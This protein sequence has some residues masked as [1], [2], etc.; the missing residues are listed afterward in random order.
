M[1]LINS[2]CI[3]TQAVSMMK[4]TVPPSCLRA[5]PKAVQSGGGMQLLA[6]VTV[7]AFD[8]THRELLHLAQLRS[9]LK[10]FGSSQLPLSNMIIDTQLLFSFRRTLYLPF[11]LKRMLSIRQCSSGEVAHSARVRTSNDALMFFLGTDFKQKYTTFCPPHT[12][13]E[14]ST[15]TFSHFSTC[16]LL[17]MLPVSSTPRS[18]VW[19]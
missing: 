11:S 6:A 10:Y 19:C 15:P 13:K 3:K 18:W 2:D 9:S 8:E 7:A 14:K 5:D 4:V 16:R 17:S 12:C 1:F